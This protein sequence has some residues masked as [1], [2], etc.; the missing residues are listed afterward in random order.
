MNKDKII[1][2]IVVVLIIVISTII[3][4]IFNFKPLID[5]LLCL[6]VPSIYLAL[7]EKKNLVK[8]AIGVLLIG[9]I[10]GF[11]F[12]FIVTYNQGWEVIR[13]V[14]PW[15]IF[16]VLPWDDLFGW[17][18]MTL[19]ILVFYEHFL[20]D[21]KNRRISENLKFV[22]IPFLIIFLLVISLFFFKPDILRIPYPY[23]IGGLL[24]IVFPVALSFSKTRFLIKFFQISSFFSIVWL[25]LEL[26]NLRNASW[27]FPGKY[28]GQVYLLGYTFPFEE[29]LF[30]IIFYSATVVAYYEYSIDDAK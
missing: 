22:L 5:G 27:I 20:D 15:K 10:V 1:D 18:L 29:L 30:W 26:V 19:F 6:L 4:L 3:A 11:I 8:I 23:L 17:M 13:L 21:E 16:G 9:G 2:L 24:A 14:F 28:I 12:D 7:R 25:V